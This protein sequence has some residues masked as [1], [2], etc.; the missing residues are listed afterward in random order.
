MEINNPNLQVVNELLSK[1]DTSQL[2]RFLM[3]HDNHDYLPS[4]Y[5]YRNHCINR[6]AVICDFENDDEFLGN[7]LAISVIVDKV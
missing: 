1:N 2:Q 7:I 5:L 4:I 6:I 3:R